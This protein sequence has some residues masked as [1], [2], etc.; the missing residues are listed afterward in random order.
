MDERRK[1]MSSTDTSSLLEALLLALALM[2]MCI[3]PYSKVEESFNVQAS[4]DIT[5]HMLLAKNSS[6]NLQGLAAFDHFQFPGVVPR[7][8]TGSF[9][10]AL[11]LY[12][13][14]YWLNILSGLGIVSGLGVKIISY[15]LVRFTLAVLNWR[16]IVSIG[17]AIRRVYG[18]TEQK[19]FLLL[20]CCQFHLLFYLSRLLPNSLAFVC[21]SFALKHWIEGRPYLSILLF[22]FATVVF[23]CD[24]IILLALT[25]L[26]MVFVRDVTLV[27]GV[28]FG[29]FSIFL[30]LLVSLPIDSYFWTPSE[31]FEQDPFLDVIQLKKLNV[32]GREII[33]PEA[34]VFFFNVIL[35][36]SS[37]WGVMPFTWF[38][39]SALP[40]ALLVAYPLSFCGIFKLTYKDQVLKF[41][42]NRRVLKYWVVT[43]LFVFVYSFSAHKETRFLY[44]VLPFFN[45]LASL[46]CS[47]IENLRKEKIENSL[48]KKAVDGVFYLLCTGI[49]VS[50]MLSFGFLFLSSQNYPGGSAIY[51]LNQRLLYSNAGDFEKNSLIKVHVGVYASMTGVTKYSVLENSDLYEKDLEIRYSKAEDEK[52][53]KNICN[54]ESEFDFVLMER[55]VLEQM[56][57]ICNENKFVVLKEFPGEPK[58]NLLEMTIEFSNAVVIL[59][60]L[61]SIST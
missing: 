1:Q 15:L 49:T 16:G 7:T 34:Q 13:V 14:S 57:E 31:D 24:V 41:S 61:K 46:A 56:S 45:F 2:Y 44:P 21:C 3:A 30:S 36:K 23:R 50:L 6:D 47:I 54:A 26:A 19:W 27:K 35:G 39:Y 29:V 55:K 25:G 53:I 51:F 20:C 5:F 40:K 37:E 9:L 43:L 38:F 4:H 22:T 18:I 12:P 58:L 8:F 10:I 32:F 11:A 42:L 17:N 52:T 28:S 59:E 33:W 48:L 60:K